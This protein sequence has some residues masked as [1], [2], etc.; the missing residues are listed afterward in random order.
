MYPSMNDSLRNRILCALD[1]LDAPGSSREAMTGALR[2]L[3]RVV[4]ESASELP[5]DLAHCLS[6]RSY[7]KARACLADPGRPHRP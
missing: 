4:V 6:R 1:L 3:D 5:G 7:A 2:E